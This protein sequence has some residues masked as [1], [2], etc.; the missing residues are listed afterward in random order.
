[1]PLHSKQDD[2]TATTNPLALAPVT[3]CSTATRARCLRLILARIR[4][5][6]SD[7]IRGLDLYGGRD[8]GPV[9]RNWFL[10]ERC[11]Y[12]GAVNRTAHTSSGNSCGLDARQRG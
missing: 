6:V 8:L 3:A 5:V 1:M 10:V 2:V 7:L 12:R 9:R 4:T 11:R